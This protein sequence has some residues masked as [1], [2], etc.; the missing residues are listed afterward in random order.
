MISRLFFIGAGL[1]L[2]LVALAKI[3]SGFGGA[4]ALKTYDPILAIDFKTLFIVVG[5]ME[6]AVG[7]LCIRLQSQL[8]RAL[9]LLW[10][11]ASIVLYRVGLV[12]VGYHGPCRCLGTFT[13]ALHIDPVA[14]D[15]G[16]RIV[17]G[18]LLCGSA[19]VICAHL[20]R[21][22]RGAQEGAA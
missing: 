13:D 14:A 16:L 7:I 9:L 15:L 18:V 10:L 11:G 21:R 2:I 5:A 19:G 1:V 8:V 20:A 17:L 3:W 12:S 6:L 4:E 22:G